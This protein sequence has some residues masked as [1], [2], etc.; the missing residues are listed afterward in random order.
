MRLLYSGQI[1][2]GDSGAINAAQCIGGLR[3]APAAQP[4]RCTRLTSC[5]FYQHIPACRANARF[6]KGALQRIIV[7][8]LTTLKR[9]WLIRRAE[10]RARRN[11][12]KHQ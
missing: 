2:R 1:A 12:R 4:Q 3:E 10:N 11:P 8:R 5:F 7:S 6:L 9:Q